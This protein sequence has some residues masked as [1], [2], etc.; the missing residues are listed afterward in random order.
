MSECIFCKIITGEIPSTKVYED[1]TVFAFLDIMPVNPGHTLVISK[2]HHNNFLEAAQEDINNIT[3]AVKKIAPAV[4]RSVDAKAFNLTT[5]NGAD[6]GQ[7]V[8]HIH[9]HIIPRYQGDGHISWQ[10]G[11]YSE[12][13]A[14]TIGKKITEQL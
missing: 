3:E 1:D 8:E 5:N 14:A 2:K 6:A 11:Q 13:E 9:F 12:G 10:Q 4:I 7:S